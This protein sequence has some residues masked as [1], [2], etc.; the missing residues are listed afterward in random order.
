[1]KD[2]LVNVKAFSVKWAC[3]Q[4][5]ISAVRQALNENWICALKKK[6]LKY[7][8]MAVLSLFTHI[9]ALVPHC[10]VYVLELD[11]LTTCVCSGG[12]LMD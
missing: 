2:V 8:K 1:M 6:W 12:L 11:V 3:D 9:Q 4:F 10:G 5:V 7:V